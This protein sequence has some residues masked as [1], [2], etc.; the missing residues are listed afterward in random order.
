MSDP[1]GLSIV[2]NLKAYGDVRLDFLARSVGRRPEEIEDM[3]ELLKKQQV[4]EI[5]DDGKVRIK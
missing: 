4:V 5:S 1:L 2:T 3:V